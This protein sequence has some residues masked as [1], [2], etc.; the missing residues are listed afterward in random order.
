MKHDMKS[1]MT[2]LNRTCRRCGTR[3]TLLQEM[4][5][6]VDPETLDCPGFSLRHW[7]RRK[8]WNIMTW[9]FLP[10]YM[11][12]AAKHLGFWEALRSFRK[13]MVRY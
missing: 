7:F 11:K 3:Y 6:A 9:R 8:V 12:A 2:D 4:E 13:F 5:M 10:A 1:P